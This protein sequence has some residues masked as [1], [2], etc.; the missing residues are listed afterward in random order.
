L[1]ASAKNQENKIIHEF[2]KRKSNNENQ[3]RDY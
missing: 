2:T 3:K 1:C